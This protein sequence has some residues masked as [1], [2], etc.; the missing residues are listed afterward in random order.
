MP[1]PL[2][3]E[4]AALSPISK[5]RPHTRL[6]SRMRS[7]SK[8]PRTRCKYEPTEAVTPRCTSMRRWMGPGS[9]ATSS[10]RARVKRLS[11]FISQ[12]SGWEMARERAVAAGRGGGGGGGALRGVGAGEVLALSKRERASCDID[13]QCQHHTALTRC[14]ASGVSPEAARSQEEIIAA[15]RR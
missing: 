7:T 1:A 3:P 10:T 6:P 12:P 8:L 15:D 5:R 11:H 13:S 14:T 4:R 2:A 9:V